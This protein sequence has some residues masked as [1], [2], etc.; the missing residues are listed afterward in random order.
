MIRFTIPGVAVPKGRPRYTSSGHAYT[1]H[2]TKAYAEEVQWIARR[3]VASQPPF[4]GPVAVRI[5]E[6]RKGKP[7]ARPDA[8]NVAKNLLDALNKLVYEDDSQVVSLLVE[9]RRDAKNPRVEVEIEE[10]RV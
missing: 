3:T 1:P 7:E 8:D 6:Y 2:R 4:T 10:V 5:V 9:K